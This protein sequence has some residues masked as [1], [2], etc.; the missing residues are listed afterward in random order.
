MER[1]PEAEVRK[2]FPARIQLY[3]RSDTL[4]V[5]PLISHLCELF[6]IHLG[7]IFPFLQR[8]R[9]LQG[10]RV[11]EVDE[12]L[13]DA[14]CAVAARFSAHPSLLTPSSDKTPVNA[15]NEVLRGFRGYPFA[16]RVREALTGALPK[17]TIVLAQACLILAF[18][19]CRT[20]DF[21]AAS[22]YSAMVSRMVQIQ[23][24]QN[25]QAPELASQARAAP[26][27]SGGKPAHER[28]PDHE[29]PPSAAEEQ[30]RQASSTDD[31]AEQEAARIDTICS[32]ILLD[33]LISLTTQ[34]QFALQDRNFD[35]PYIVQWA[36]GGACSARRPLSLLLRIVLLQCQLLEKLDRIGQTAMDAREF[37]SYL[38]TFAQKL[39]GSGSI[40]RLSV[41]AYTVFKADPT[42][43]S[44]KFWD[45]VSSSA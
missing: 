20:K 34:H 30:F 21:V 5:P 8:D 44:T 38:E 32:V 31:S 28:R 25:V 17:P 15:E 10:M 39:K 1:F 16:L 3:D 42:Q 41:P 37:R 35:V 19:E 18:D 40:Q 7:C 12:I 29:Q 22:I 24:L 6:F 14:M 9:F 4:P 33:R 36:A 43:K 11:K 26:G 23:G 2:D 13:V 45:P 27:L